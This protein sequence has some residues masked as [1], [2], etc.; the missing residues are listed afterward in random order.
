[1]STSASIDWGNLGFSYMQTP[2]HIRYTWRD[3]EWSEGELIDEPYIQMHIAATAL[4]YGQSGFE[5]MKAFMGQDGKVRIFRPDENAKRM[6]RTARR[7]CMAE[8][9]PAMFIDAC[10]RVVAANRD[11][12]P[13]Y[14]SGGAMYIRPLLFGTG[15][16]IGL[17][18]AD[19]YT[20]IV[21]V[22][23]VGPYYKG[24]LK[25]VDALILDEYDRAA[26]HG[27]GHVKVAGNYA[28]GMEPNRVAAA[29]GYPIVLFLDAKEHRYV[30]EFGT[31]NFI[32]I[33]ADQHYVTASS[34][35]ILL[36]IINMSLQQLAADMGMP[37]EVRP[38]ELSEVSSFAEV[39]ACGTAV[40]LTPIC[41]IVSDDE[42]IEI[43]SPDACGPT[44]QKLYDMVQQIQYGETEDRH[45]WNL[46]VD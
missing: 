1:M 36:S 18:P 21:M 6:A 3:G 42:T 23:P 44:L 7:I 41:K 37:V 19:E 17:Q 24:G 30:E 46:I 27:V 8:V 29:K 2:Y 32:A 45:G 26:P 16:R 22:N 40:V 13:P 5:G 39:G 35:S 25:P 43:G 4:H 33:T 38:I 31:S 34:S 20:F 15:V 10:T 28:A 12:V 11:Y 14:G 9:P